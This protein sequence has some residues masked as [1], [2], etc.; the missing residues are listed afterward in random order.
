VQVG[1]LGPVEVSRDGS[2]VPIAGARMR[3]LLTRLALGRGRAVP[4][5]ELIDAVWGAAESDDPANALQ[6][7]VSRLRRALGDPASVVPTPGGYRLAVDADDVDV[8]RFETL[9]RTGRSDLRAGR[10]DDAATALTQALSLWR[11]TALADLPDDPG[12]GALDDARQAT[13]ED[14]LEADIGRGLGAEASAEL[15]AAVAAAPMRERAV[16]LLM[17]ALVAQGRDADA[18]TVY[19]RTRAVL[20]DELGADPGAAL[21]E[22]HLRILRSERP[23][24]AEPK[25][26]RTNLRA[27]LTTFVGRETDMAAVAERLG[28]HRLVTLVGP[29]GAGKTRLAGEVGAAVTDRFRDGVWLVELAGVTDPDDVVGAAV[30]TLGVREAALFDS[31]STGGARRGPLNQLHDALNDRDLLLILDNCEHVLDAVA[32]LVEYLLTRIPGL[33]ILTTSRESLALPGE[34][35]YPV[36]PLGHSSDGAAVALFLDRARAIRSA[37]VDDLSAVEEICRRLDGL[38]LAIELAAARTRGLTVRQIA[39]RLNDRFRLLSGGNRV[40]VA[41][42]RTLRAVVEWSWSLLTAD[43]QWLLEQLSV[44]AGGASVESADAIW[45]AAGRAGDTVDLLAALVDK[46]LL[47]LVNASTARYRMLET[48]REF[49]VDRLAERDELAVARARHAEHF[50]LWAVSIEPLTRTAEQLVWIARLNDERDNIFAAI[51]HLV[52]TRAADDAVSLAM[53]MGWCWTMRGEHAVAVTWLGEAL[54]VPGGTDSAERTVAC[55]L[56]TMN[57]GIWTPGGDDPSMD[58]EGLTPYADPERNPMAVVMLAVGLVFGNGY[59]AADKYL[60]DMIERTEDWPQATL[61]MVRAMLAENDGNLALSR[62]SLNRALAAFQTLGERFGLAS[63][64]ELHARLAVLDGDL[65]GTLA[66]LDQAAAITRELGAYED[67]G[68]AM[69]WRAD[70]QLR[71]HDPAAARADLVR[72]E[73]DFARVGSVFGAVLTDAVRGQILRYDGEL[74]LARTTIARARQRVSTEIRTTPPQALAML[75]IAA[76]EVE[77]ADRQ[78]DDGLP[79]ATEAARTA[80]ATR[81]LPIVSQT[82][83]LWATISWQRG[84]PALAAELLG[85]SDGLRG[86][87]DPTHPEV[88]NLERNLLGALG[89]PELTRLREQGRSLPRD[90]ALARLVAAAGIDNQPATVP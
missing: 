73:A 23:P 54:S 53:A 59:A 64:L 37:P 25:Q 84:D 70:A 68:A 16:G 55:A 79:L 61:L 88:I 12:A 20:A 76:A 28:E 30:G 33:R 13:L 18:L 11:G 89:A 48:I 40:A 41:R 31:R 32:E 38:P 6:S 69:C 46:S 66:T 3:A 49:G 22:R 65:T 8:H 74:A 51:Q 29:G 26:A 62:Q 78:L 77:V 57:A 45:V 90:D 71:L 43:E 15:E 34:S 67:A 60:A 85:V 72:G 80:I 10:Y 14:R 56:R 24:A 7:L 44:F 81:D 52:D 42:H 35:L 27:A 1:V 4:A 21:S 9:S 63:C 58:I 75:L 17:D 2:L 39:D 87:P 83:V 50:R 82:V 36:P 86:A 19:E 5:G 47:Q